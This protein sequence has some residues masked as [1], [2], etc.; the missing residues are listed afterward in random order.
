MRKP[1]G[2]DRWL[3]KV[4]L[5]ETPLAGLDACE[6]AEPVGDAGDE[7]SS[8]STGKPALGE[9]VRL[10]DRVYTIAGDG[11]VAGGVSRGD[12]SEPAGV[13]AASGVHGFTRRRVESKRRAMQG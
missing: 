4:R 9:L 8:V 2:A 5:R 12:L 6:R 13:S 10:S 3:G 1:A 11:S 7:R